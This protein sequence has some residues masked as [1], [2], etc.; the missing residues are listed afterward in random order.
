MNILV[1]G[2]MGFIGSNLCIDLLNDGHSV[3]GFDNLYSS[4][5]DPSNRIKSSLNERKNWDNFV[6]YKLDI[7]NYEHMISIL[8][9]NRSFK[10]DAIVNLAAVGSISRSFESPELTM[11]N[12]VTG[13]S[14]VLNL[15]RHL[16]IKKF[17]YASSSSVYSRSSKNPRQES[18]GIAPALSPYALSKQMNE[19]IADI[20][21][22]EH[23]SF[24]GL[25]FFNVYGPGQ[26]FDSDY[27]SV[28]PKFINSECPVVY[29]DGFQSRDF[30]FVSDVCTA[31]KNCLKSELTGKY[32]F[33]IGSGR[34]T[35]LNDI[36]KILK[37]DKKAK[38][39]NP[40]SFDVNRSLADIN[41]AKFLIGYEPKHSIE[42]GIEITSKYY[43]SLKSNENLL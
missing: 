30:T 13:F 18:D 9:A 38:Y 39:L 37:K 36:L 34:E 23:K 26:C 5:I 19:N 21:S 40:R 7:T 11:H 33:N 32:I 12:N 8:T 15:T 43:E 22:K 6:F 14:N 24:F 25:R 3:I 41:L 29:G 35:S 10:I 2:C 31:I 28:I 1:T 27:S 4:S 20:F 42:K 17:V 16:E